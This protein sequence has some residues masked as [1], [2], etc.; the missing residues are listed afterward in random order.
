MNNVEG[1]DNRCPLITLSSLHFNE[2]IVI[3]SLFF[4]AERSFL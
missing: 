4:L 1:G 2:C 3:K